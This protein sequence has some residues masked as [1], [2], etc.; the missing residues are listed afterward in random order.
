M[1]IGNRIRQ[2]R[3]EKKLSQEELGKLIGV[4][5]VSICGYEKGTRT[6]T[7]DTFLNLIEVLELEPLYALG[8]EKEIVSDNN[9]NYKTRMSS[10]DIQIIKEIKKHRELYNEMCNNPKRTID[11]VNLKL[12][13]S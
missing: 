1:L 7:I 2:A 11:I 9:S 12:F 4:T 8:M 13:K 6:P 3:K 5:K 10:D